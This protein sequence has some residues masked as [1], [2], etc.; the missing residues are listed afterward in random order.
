MA[1][2]NSERVIVPINNCA[3]STDSKVPAFYCVHSAS[4]VAGTDF[5]DLAER[6][7]PSVRFYGIQA[8]PKLM[9]DAEFGRSVESVA[10]YYAEA[11]VKFQPTGPFLVGGYCVGGVIAIAMVESLRARGR[12]VGP[13]LVIDGVPENTGVAIRRW[14]PAYWLDL[15]RNARGWMSHGDLMRTRTLRSLIWSISNNATAIVKGAVGLKRGQKMG[16]GYGIEGIM[17]VSRYQPAH[18]SFINRLFSA[19]F[20]YAPRNF[21]GE[22]VV[23]EATVKPLLHPPQIGRIWRKFAPRSVIVEIVG[24]HISMMHE[25]YVDRLAKDIR[26]RVVEYFSA[27][28]AR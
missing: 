7:E 5:L 6:L 27:N 8:P 1:S 16:G 25:P 15:A 13:L 12:E 2:R 28:S 9:P 20:D 18:K 22:V 4:G 10:D 23:Y 14:T 19:M 24:T 3:L 11:L 17:D 21:S 26:S